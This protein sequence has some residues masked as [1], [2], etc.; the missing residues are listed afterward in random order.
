MK[1]S[2]KTTL[3]ITA[4][5]LTTV[6]S[7]ILGFYAFDATKIKSF[8]KNLTFYFLLVNFLLF[9][10]Q[11]IKIAFRHKEKLK[12][13]LKNSKAAFL[14]A[15]I[16]VLVLFFSVEADFKILAD[17][18]NLL[19][20]AMA[21]YDEHQCYNPTQVLYHNHGMKRTLQSVIDM[22]PAF[23]PF[24]IYLAHAITGYRP[25]NGF[26]VNLIAAFFIL[27]LIYYLVGHW[28][29][30]NYGMAAMLLLVA[31]PLFA[32]YV[33]S[34]GFETV[35]L[36]WFL[37]LTTVFYLFVKKP[38]SHLTELL[39]L[40][41]PLLAQTR[42]ESV[43]AVFCIIPAIFYK[44]SKADFSNL[45]FRSIITPFLFLPVAWLRIITCNSKSFQVNDLSQAF[46]FDLLIKNIQ[47]AVPFFAGQDPNYGTL[48]LVSLFAFAGFVRILIDLILKKELRK[49]CFSPFIIGTTLLVISHALARFAYYWGNLQLQYTARLGIIFLPFIVFFALYFFKELQSFFKFNI[50]RLFIVA[51]ALMIYSLP[52]AARC[53]AIKEIHFYR[54]FKTVRKFIEKQNLK[55]DNLL[56][57][58]ELANLYVPL[59]YSS[60]YNGYARI[61]PYLI[62]NI[63]NNKD[64]SNIIVIEKI[65]RK[66]GKASKE[67]KL[68]DIFQLKA[69]YEK[70]FSSKHNLRFYKFIKLHK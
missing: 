45:T 61:H 1:N 41:L 25:E 19:G 15:A 48:P 40:T 51:T 23:F 34:C 37:I 62:E 27:L 22:R 44:L 7:L 66:T 3:I 68:N 13:F 38:D 46:G 53:E 5:L 59:R 31:H 4:G 26:L 47:K 55:K 14:L 21:M 2:K 50:N 11:L 12:D 33:R 35:N 49:T 18:T 69:I 17:E 29:G 28:L 24:Q 63:Q 43:L 36:L 65:E 6:I 20:T 57:I 58:S 9:S 10:Q 8:Y 16:L 30:N 64:Y 60:L 42:Y 67:T 54:E 70:K 56:L 32:I 52:I 39:F